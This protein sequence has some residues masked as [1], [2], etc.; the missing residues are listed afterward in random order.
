MSTRIAQIVISLLVGWSSGDAAVSPP[1]PASGRVADTSPTL[2]AVFG[3]PSQAAFGSAVFVEQLARSQDLEAAAQRWYCHFLGKQWHEAGEANWMAAWRRVY[4]RDPGDGRRIVA[5]LRAIPDP[6]AR[7]SIA[8]LLEGHENPDAAMKALS[9]VY[10]DP[11]MGS[12]QVFTLG[13][14]A[15]LS[16]VLIAGRARS[17]AATFLVF[18][19]D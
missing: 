2:Q 9:A 19:M 15:A 1:A 16:E 11:A 4:T 18:L 8:V 7:L 13:D 10:D 6:A 3:P 5:E 14:G 12:L 17:G